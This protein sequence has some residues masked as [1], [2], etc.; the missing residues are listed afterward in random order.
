M[1]TSSKTARKPLLCPATRADGTPCQAGGQSAHGGY[2][3]GHSPMASDA[4]RKGGLAR[5]ADR[6][7]KRLP[8]RLREVVG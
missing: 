1:T 8:L 2:C 7:D 6:M 4:R 3:V 5:R